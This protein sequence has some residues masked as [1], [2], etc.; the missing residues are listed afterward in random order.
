M[1]YLLIEAVVA[2]GRFVGCLLLSGS[3][4]NVTYGIQLIKTG[5]L[6]IFWLKRRKKLEFSPRRVP[7]GNGGAQKKG[8]DWQFRPGIPH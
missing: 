5:Q 3:Y 8:S 7:S 6:N 1:V 4:S 2:D